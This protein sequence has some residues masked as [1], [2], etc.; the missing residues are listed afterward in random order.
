MKERL[1]NLNEIIKKDIPV[2]IG[3]TQNKTTPVFCD[4]ATSVGTNLFFADH[5]YTAD[6]AMLGLDGYQILY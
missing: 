6:Y 1:S 2:V 3:T 4:I 5:E